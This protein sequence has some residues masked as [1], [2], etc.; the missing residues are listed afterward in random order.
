MKKAE[1]LTNILLQFIWHYSTQGN[2]LSLYYE[3]QHYCYLQEKYYTLTFNILAQS[4]IG[5][6]C[7]YVLLVMF[8]I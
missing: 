6:W 1:K 7:I 2:Y 3:Y 4:F 8:F 5:L